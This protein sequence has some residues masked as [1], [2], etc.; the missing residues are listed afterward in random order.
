MPPHHVVAKVNRQT[1]V[2]VQLIDTDEIDQ[3]RVDLGKYPAVQ[4]FALDGD[5][6]GNQDVG[7]PQ[8]TENGD[9]SV[10]R[11]GIV[12]ANQTVIFAFA[13]KCSIQVILCETAVHLITA[14]YN[15]S[16]RMSA[17]VLVDEIGRIVR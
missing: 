5:V 13:H 4:T 16:F 17:N 12:A 11:F 8:F 6:I 7:C 10:A 1:V 9:H 14:K 15:S 3:I 2:V